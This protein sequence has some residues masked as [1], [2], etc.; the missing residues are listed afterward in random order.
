MTFYYSLRYTLDPK[1]NTPEQDA[2]LLRFCQDAQID[3][4]AF[5][6]N[7]EELNAGHLTATQ[8]QVWLDAIVPVQQQLASIGV[9]TSLNPWT[10]IMHSD[11]G[12]TVP[13][14]LGFDTMVDVDGR[15]A[16][17]MACPADPRWVD[18]MASCY[19][20]F[21]QIHPAE[22]WLE[23]DFRHYNHTPLRLACFCPRH[24]ELY[25]Q[26]LGAFE[27]RAEFVVNLLA[28]GQPR[29]ERNAYLTVARREM[30]NVARRI[31]T[32]VHAISPETKVALM[33]S[34][35]DWHAVEGRDWAGLLDALAG[36]EHERVARPHLPAYN[37]V[38]PNS[39]GRIFEQYTRTTAAY[40]GPDATLLPELEN[41]M[42]SPFAKS[43][44][45]TQFQI[46]STVLV[47]ARGIL[48][49][50][51]D[52]MGNGITPDYGYAAMLATSKPF[53]NAITADRMAMNQTRGIKVL[54]NQNSTAT[55]HT[56]FAVGAIR[57]GVT[58]GAPRHDEQRLEP[59]DLLPEETS[60]ANLLSMYGF[61][62][63]ITPWTSDLKLTGQTLAVSGQFL[64][65]LDTAAVRQLLSDN[66]VL[67]DGTSVQVLLDRDLGDLLHVQSATWLPV[68]SQ[69][70]TYMEVPGRTLAGVPNPRS[71]MLQHIGDYLQLN[72]VPGAPVEVWSVAKNAAGST[73]GPVVTAID[74]HLFVLPF[75]ND[76][77]YGWEA[78]YNNFEQEL[79]QQ[80]LTVNG[81]ADYL[82]GMPNVKLVDTGKTLWLS[83][84][85]LDG[86]TSITWHPG[87]KVN[88]KIATI[89]TRTAAGNVETQVNIERR[90]DELVLPIEVAGLQTLKISL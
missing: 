20:Q 19:A 16:D 13:A 37:E 43:K 86:Y 65:N 34:F 3:N 58:P 88:A 62:T 4:V 25:A 72:Y 35:P 2:R 90:G 69:H 42:Y 81:D 71:T 47:G 32:A 61:S 59:A 52:M 75:N 41:Y 66:R 55:L 40:L 64:R 51:F 12:P 84:F 27:T 82:V 9:S 80:L 38:A 22:L 49:N 7:S 14:A 54:V 73:L 28:P 68:R 23:D 83:N 1:T 17:A 50:L 46:E 10:T 74:Q 48:L 63:T 79:F 29:P 21:A 60:W 26:E 57:G 30:I 85:G 39:Y 53:L 56:E 87:R 89:Q 11:R 8:T 18:Y 78:H 33:T 24:M 67:L 15:Q 45:F 70:Q 5:F 6:I 76:P 44:T 77:K 36:T 31:E